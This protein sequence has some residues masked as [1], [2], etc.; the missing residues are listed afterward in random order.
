MTQWV[1]RGRYCTTYISHVEDT[2]FKI[3]HIF[4]VIIIH[5]A[6]GQIIPSSNGA[7]I[8]LRFSFWGVWM[9]VLPEIVISHD[10]ND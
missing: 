5:R 1:Q 3:L 9:W 6:I 7:F 4:K 8:Y 10:R 2:V